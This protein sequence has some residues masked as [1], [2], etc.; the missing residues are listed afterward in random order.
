[1]TDLNG[2]RDF[3][4][5]VRG[6]GPAGAAAAM[7][8]AKLGL[9]VALVDRKRFPRDKLCGGGLTGRAMA[10]HRRIFGADHP[11]VPMEVRRDFAFH[12]FGQDLGMTRDAP[13]IHLAMRRELDRHLVD[14][15]LA[16]GAVDVTGH[17]LDL[18][19]G[20]PAGP[21]L[22]NETM[23]L[24][25]PLLIAA[26]GVNS[27]TA[28]ALFGRAFDRDRIGFALEIEH[29]GADPARPLRI[30]FGAAEW[31]YGWQFPKTTGTTVGVGGIMARNP[32][33]KRAMKAYMARLDIPE[34]ARVKGQFLPFGGFRKRPGQGRVLLAGDAAGLVDPITGEGIAHA[35]H[36]GELAAQA[37]A[38]ALGADHPE[39]ALGRYTTALRPI[40]NGLT[41]ARLLRTIMFRH[42]LRPAFIRSFRESRRLREEYL[43]LLAGETDYAPLMRKTARRMPGFAARALFGR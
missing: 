30:D 36:S 34:G 5:I 22:F 17:A 35:L 32:D 23:R 27:P 31:G 38:Q 2:R 11:D 20:D 41:L 15:A 40:H 43:R 24:T 42:A 14:R 13:P 19:P 33:L 10:H 39:A 26:D 18:D 1:M 21:A 3:D 9:R 29:P 7:T 12:A 4:L 37:A 25:A 6:A 8:A 16:A 28:N